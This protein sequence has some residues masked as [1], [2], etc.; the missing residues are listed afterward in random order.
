MTNDMLSKSTGEIHF[1][2]R[3]VARTVGARL[4]YGILAP[5][6]P[7]VTVCV[8]LA[9]TLLV[10]RDPTRGGYTKDIDGHRTQCSS[11]ST[12]MQDW[13]RGARQYVL[14]NCDLIVAGEVAAGRRNLLSHAVSRGVQMRWPS[15]L[16]H[17]CVYW[18]IVDPRLFRWTSV[19]RLGSCSRGK[20]VVPD[21]GGE[22]AGEACPL[23]APPALLTLGDIHILSKSTEPLPT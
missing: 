7:C 18:V 8:S 10:R 13:C 21:A 6:G 12:P 16:A 3:Q 20:N 15:N 2:L 5:C 22:K 9:K 23:C 4:F 14:R 1:S 11:S 19:S 17:S